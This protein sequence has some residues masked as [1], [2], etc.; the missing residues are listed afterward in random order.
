MVKVTRALMAVLLS[1]LILVA[2]APAPM[3]SPITSALPTDEKR[4]RS[5]SDEET[6]TLTSLK[7]VD[8]YPL[9]TMSYYGS[10]NRRVSSTEDVKPWGSASIPNT[11]LIPLSRTWACSLFTAFGGTGNMLYGRNFDWKFSPALLL[12]TDPPD[13]YASVSMV[14]IAYLGYQ[15]KKSRTITDLPINK[16]CEL[17]GAPFIP[18]DGMNEQGLVV[19]MAA[20]P[21]GNMRPDPE[22]E[23]MSSVKVI[24]KILDHASN[25]DE[26]VAILQNYNINMGDVPIH[27]LIAA[28]SGRSVLVEFYRGKMVVIPNEKQ[29][30]L[31]T[32]FLLASVGQSAHRKCRR[33]D[34]INQR[35]TETEGYLTAQ[36]AMDLLADVSVRRTQWSIVYGMSTGDIT[37]AMGRNYEKLHTFHLSSA[38]D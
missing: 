24:R 5:L 17:L 33:Y 20:V 21:P 2:C 16:R 9:Y 8:N 7:R 1:A 4:S 18:F 13:G 29:W 19:G 27:Y 15:E 14:D 38:G 35:L 37:V 11:P 10:Y 32:N 23:T 12:F 28:P 26:A 3:P 30:H 6:A 22:K 34:T 31:A 36:K 25:V